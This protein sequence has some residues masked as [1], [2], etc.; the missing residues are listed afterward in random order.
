MLYSWIVWLSWH[1]GLA[2]CNTDTLFPGGRPDQAEIG[3]HKFLIK[4]ELS[5]CQRCSGQ[6]FLFLFCFKLFLFDSL[7][8]VSARKR[9]RSGRKKKVRLLLSFR[10][11]NPL[12]SGFSK[13]AAVDNTLACDLDEFKT[14]LEGLWTVYE[15]NSN[16]I[17]LC[18][19]TLHDWFK[20]HPLC[21]PNRS[22][23]KTNHDKLVQL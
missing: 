22:N 23:T 1:F 16:L 21:H 18:I 4:T 5:E 10:K 17:G 7:S 19:T 13:S 8:D 11:A 3:L 6:A 2:D 14:K 12:R 15:S 20:T 9:T